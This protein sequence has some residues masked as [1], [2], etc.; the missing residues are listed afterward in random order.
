MTR[1]KRSRPAEDYKPRWDK[2]D[3][4]FEVVSDMFG[5]PPGS[6]VADPDTSG[7][8][9]PLPRSD[10]VP[11]WS[12]PSDQLPA[13]LQRALDRAVTPEQR[14]EAPKPVPATAEPV[15]SEAP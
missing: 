8:T 9:C 10:A 11:G 12:R 15:S 14:S 6:S 1:A 4:I 2:N 13:L 3:D 5:Q 7:A